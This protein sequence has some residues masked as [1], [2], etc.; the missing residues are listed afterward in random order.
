MSEQNTVGAA[1]HVQI[2]VPPKPSPTRLIEQEADEAVSFLQT[3]ATSSRLDPEL[4]IKLNN[5]M[6]TIVTLKNTVITL[7]E[8]GETNHDRLTEVIRSQRLMG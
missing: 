3:L 2:I 7:R 6:H 1:S 4:R 5:I 8:Q